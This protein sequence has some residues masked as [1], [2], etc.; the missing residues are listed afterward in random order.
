MKF[1][2]SAFFLFWFLAVPVWS[3]SQCGYLVLH[4]TETSSYDHNTRSQ[5]LAMFQAIGS[6]NNFTVVTDNDGSEF[7]SLANLQQYAVVIFSNT[8]GNS[9]LNATQRANFEAY[10]NAGGSYL[11]IHAASDTY[12]HSTAN[13]GGTGGWDW[14]AENVSGAS[15]QTNPNHTSNG[16]NNDMTHSQPGHPILAG[17]P[18][19]WNKTEEYYYWENGYINTTFTELLRVGSTGSNSYDAPRRMAHYKDLAGGGRAFYTALGHDQSNYTSDQNFINLITNAVVWAAAPNASGGSNL[20]VTAAITDASC[21]GTDG[22]IDITV[23]GGAA[24][25]GF[26][27]SNG[28][29]NEDI[30]GLAPGTYTV[31]ITDITGCTL[32][33]S[34]VVAGS[35]ALTAFIIE[36]DPVVC[37]GDS[38]GALTAFPF[39]GTAPYTYNWSNGGTTGTILNLPAGTYTVTITDGTG[40][41]A[42]ETYTLLDPTQLNVTA[43]VGSAI[44]C[45]GGSTGTAVATGSGGVFPYSFLWSDGQVTDTAFNLGPGN[46]KVTLTDGNGCF[47]E[48]S[49]TMTITSPITASLSIVDP[50]N[51]F[52][53]TT[54]AL[55]AS[56]S[57]GTLP[58]SYLWSN[59]ATTA[60]I[61]GLTAGQYSVTIS[62]A[63]GCSVSDS[64][65]LSQPPQLI[66]NAT[67]VTPASCNGASDGVAAVAITGGVT[68]YS[69]LW[70]NGMT[71]DTVINMAVGAYTVSITDANGCVDSSSVTVGS[72]IPWTASLTQTAQINCFGDANGEVSVSIANG[73]LYAPFTYLWGDGQTTATAVNLGAGTHTVTITDIN[74]C[75]TVESITITQPALLTGLAFV[76]DSISCA[77]ITD[78]A[79]TINPTG[80]TTPYT[81]LWNNGQTGATATALGPGSYNVTVTDSS[82]CTVSDNVVLIEPSVLTANVSPVDPVTCNGGSD[83]SA[84]VSASG[85]TGPYTYL[86]SDGQTADTAINLA[87][88]TYTATVTDAHACIASDSVTLT[89][90]P[91]LS[92]ILSITTD[93]SCN[94]DSN[95]A[96]TATVT[97]GIAP[98]GYAWAGGQSTAT[99]SNLQ[100]GIY[101]IIVTDAVGCTISGSITLTEPLPL[102]AVASMTQPTSCNGAANGEATVVP[103]GGTSPYTYLW[104]DGQ[105]DSVAVGLAVGLYD[106]TVTDA[107]GCIAT[108]STAISDSIPWF[109][110]LNQTVNIACFGDSTAEVS[111]FI[112]GGSG[113]S[114][115]SFLWSNGATTATVT[116][117]PAGTHTVT[118]SDA[119]GC[120]AVE[121]ITITQP[122]LM[123]ATATVTDSINC[124]GAPDGVITASG[125]GGV[126]PYSY[127]WNTG[128]TTATISGVSAGTYVVTVTD[129]N[130]CKDIDSVT[131]SEP[132]VLSVTAV[133]IQQVSCNG[134]NDGSAVAIASGG[135]PSYSYIWGNG[136][137]NDTTTGLL[138]LTYGITVTDSKGCIASS[139][140]TMSEPSAVAATFSITNNISCNGASD[141][142]ATVTPSGGTGPYTYLWSNGQ[143]TATATGLA[144]GT[145]TVSISDAAN[146]T[147]VDSITLSEPSLLTASAVMT[148]PTSCNG[149]ANGEALASATGGTAPYSYLWNNGQTNALA[150]G[151]AVGVY[152]VTVTDAGGCLDSVSVAINDSIPWT[153]T[154]NPT[155]G[156][157]CFGDSTASAT[158]FITGGSGSSPFSYLW[159]DGQTTTTAFNLPAGTHSVTITDNNGC[160]SSELITISQ[161]TQLS[162][163]TTLVDSISCFGFSD[164]SATVVVT[165]GMPSYSYLWGNGQ[166]NATAVGLAAGTYVVTVTDANGCSATD[167]I[168]L[169]QP[170]Q[171]NA[172]AS[173]LQ[174]V[175]CNGGNDGQAMVTASGGRPSYTY[176]WTNG[177]TTATATNLSATTHTVTVTDAGGC[178]ATATATPSEPQALTVSLS[179]SSAISCNGVSDGEVT[180]TPAGG[181][182]GYTYLWSDGQTSATATGLAAGSYSVTITDANGCTATNTINVTEPTLLTASATMTQAASCNGVADGEAL[183]TASGGTA[184]YSYLWSNGQTTATAT[185]LVAGVYNVTVTDA[186]GC[187]QTANVSINNVIPWTATLNQTSTIDCFG[188]ATATVSTIITGG[189]GSNPF[190]YLWSDGQ[191][192]ATASNLPAGTH[193]VTITDRNGCT[194]SEIITITEP[195]ELLA[196]ASVVDSVSCFGFSDGSASVSV[197]G[198]TPAYS[199]LWGNGQ[200]GATAI[201]LVAGTYVV[202]VTDANGC[203]ATDNI[204]LSQPAQLSATA[205][206]LQDVS[207]NGG[208][209][210][211]AVVTASG[212]RPGYTYLWNNGQTTATA[213]NLSATTYTA[214][215]TDAG[216]CT[217]TATATPA[218]PQPLTVSLA[219]SN[220]ISCNGASDGEITATPA[221]GTAG[222]SYLWSNGQT[223]ATA[224]GL[225]AG[226]YSVT[227]T[228]ANGCTATN[229]INITQPAVLVAS[230]TMTQSASCNGA[231]NGEASASASGGT[232]PYSYLWSDGQTTAVATA[233]A[234]GIYTVTITDA[235]G[236][237][238]TASV[239]INSLIP[240]TA[241]IS[242]LTG[243]ACFGDSTATLTV[244]IANG[245]G[246]TPFNYVWSNGATTPS[247]SNL[248]AGTHSVTITDV[249]NCTSSEFFTVSEPA[250]L[251]LSTSVL[252]SIS[253]N[254]ATDGRATVL[255]NGGTPNY[256]YL[257]GNGQTSVIAT[258]LGAGVLTVTVTDANGCSEVASVTMTEPGLLSGTAAETQSI[259]CNG[260]TN[261]EATA[262]PSGGTAPYTYLWSNN[263]SSQTAVGLSAGTYTVT[264]TDAGGCTTTASVSLVDPPVLSVAANMSSQAT[265][266]GVNDGVATA[267]VNGGVGP[268]TYLWSDGQTTASA[269]NLMAGSYS[270]IVTDANA[271]TASAQVNIT[272]GTPWTASTAVVNPI[273]CF[274]GNDGSVSVNIT[275][276]TGPFTY[277]WSNGGTQNTISG[278]IA[279]TYSVT[280][281][282]ALGCTDIQSITLTEPQSMT[283]SIS[284]TAAISC[285]GGADGSVSVTVGGG[286]TPYSYLWGDGQTT[287]IA[288]GLAAGTHTVTAT[289]AG[290][291]T[292]TDAITITEPA[293]L[294]GTLAVINGVS[295]F[296]ASDGEIGITASGGTAPY[297]Y[298]WSNGQ[299]TANI[300]GL[301]SGTYSVTLTDANAC[302]FTDNITINQPTQIVLNITETNPISCAGA[303]DG[304]LTVTATGGTGPYTYQWSNGQST[305]SATNIASG[306][307]TVT[308][309]DANGCS[310]S[311][312]SAINQPQLLTANINLLAPVSCNGQSDASLEVVAG[313]GTTPYSYNWNTGATTNIISNLAAGNYTVTVTDGNGCTQ[314][315][316][317]TVVDPN[318]IAIT[319]NTIASVSCNGGNDG[320]VDAT[321]SG[322]T[323]PYT[324]LWSNGQT[325]ATASN[326]SAGTYSLTVTDAGGCTQTASITLGEPT[327]LI[328]SVTLV[329]PISC[330]GA[331]DGAAN[332]VVSGGTNPYSYLWQNGET[333]PT[334]F[335]LGVG[336]HSVSVTDANGCTTLASISLIEPSPLQLSLNVDQNVS[337]FGGNDG[338]ISAAVQ[339][340]T[341]PYSY[342]W[343]NGQTM[344]IATALSTGTYSLI[345]TDSAGCTISANA[346]VNEPADIQITLAISAPISCAGL[347]DGEVSASVSGGTGPYTYLWSDG[348]TSATAIGL[349][350]GTHTLTITDANG[351]TQ[352]EAITL[353][354]PPSVTASIILDT[355]ISCAGASDGALTAVPT[356]GT[357]GYTYLW[358]DGQTTVSATNLS[359][360]IY[361]VTI[362]DASG[363]QAVSSFSLLEPSLLT[364]SVSESS[365]ISCNGIADGEL[366]AT[367]SGGT[368]TYAYSWSNGQAG[369]TVTGLGPG[370]Y[371]VTVT[372]SRGCQ[373]SIDYTLSEPLGLSLTFNI[374]N[375][376]NCFGDNN[377][378]ISVSGT[379]ATPP[380]NFVWSSGQTGATSSNLSAGFHAVIATDANGCAVS[381]SV[382]LTEPPQIIPTINI[383]N[384]I[385]CAG[386]AD[387]AATVS[388]TGGTGGYTYLWSNGQTSATA[389]GLVDGTY[390]VEITDNSGCTVSDTITIS[391]PQ[392]IDISFQTIQPISCFGAADGEILAQPTGGTQPYTYAWAH[393]PTT[394]SISGLA[395]ATYI[396]TVTDGGNC[397]ATDSVFLSQ[398]DSLSAAFIVDQPVSC[399]GLTDGSVTVTATGGTGPYSF[400]WSNGSAGQTVSNLGGGLHTV[401]ISDANGCTLTDSVSLAEPT[402]I[403]P[404]VEVL[405][406]VSCF[407]GKDGII[408]ASATGGAGGF[409]YSWSSGHAGDT[410]SNLFAGQYI[411]TVTDANGCTAMDS[412]T[413]LEPTELL[414][415]AVELNAASCSSLSDGSAQVTASG[416][417][418]PYSFL[419]SDGQTEDTIFDLASG[420]YAVTVTDSV[421]CAVTDSVYIS[422]DVPWL[423]EVRIVDSVSCYGLSDGSAEVVLDAN[424][425]GFTYAW[426]DGQTTPKAVNLEAAV[427]TVLVTDDIGCDTT[428]TID[429]PGK[430]S[431]EIFSTVF[432]A[433]PQQEDGAIRVDSIAN[434]NPPYTYVWSNGIDGPLN[435]NLGQGSYSLLVIDDDG[436]EGRQSYTVDTTSFAWEFF[437]AEPD[438]EQ[439]RVKLTWTTSREIDNDYFTVERSI[440]SVIFESLLDE[441][442][443]GNSLSPQSYE[444][445]DFEPIPGVSF[446]RLKQTHRNG[447][448]T[449]FSQVRRVYWD[450]R[451]PGFVFVRPVP[452]VQ[453]NEIIIEFQMK[454]NEDAD[455]IMYNDLHQEVRVKLVQRAEGRQIVTF[456]SVGLSAGHYYIMAR[457]RTEIYSKQI[458]IIE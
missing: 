247:V 148:Q 387:G 121:S 239:G 185:G 360:G 135:S 437:D 366:T 12:R 138:A 393:G 145:Y 429:L 451:A 277:N 359:V 231:T 68:P 276:S 228:D 363:C 303:S 127:D 401:I 244:S 140:I 356:G 37:A 113:S 111:I 333:T 398:P 385:S 446:Y 131:L 8:S 287:A 109:A 315:A 420:W 40:C 330:N 20:S 75:A 351:C 296:G 136:Q 146:C 353:T 166:T 298:L 347:A 23:T 188:D 290:G 260:G 26:V 133:A 449:Y 369:P 367:A 419:W 71:T 141:G 159:S 435:T 170:I 378:V 343:S 49:V 31:T 324:Y 424:P 234:A 209:D 215:V 42:T 218:E 198:G 153:A 408:A 294:T 309:T 97:G 45:S 73:A 292:I 70:S 402:A 312:S 380:Y 400:N 230:A 28:S 391:E 346:T 125:T 64:V 197:V 355:P 149:S 413:V 199:Y 354:D 192:S 255:A 108:S 204:T 107:N 282:D 9:I 120:T 55:L 83:G 375:P 129:A 307:Y 381:D 372:D 245:N 242:Q 154:V 147:L 96:V 162:T 433:T 313:G 272:N 428:M 311:A 340:G 267:V 427:F 455:I 225:V 106:V 124:N 214:T 100:A 305:A 19:P 412:A 134:G 368:P 203:T 399:A 336:T 349:G 48:D 186:G 386:L 161:P 16:H 27:W 177:Q 157:D 207:C 189:N 7:N 261:G 33:D 17:I 206:V 264:I 85:G 62:D 376:L 94:G 382:L 208:N 334:V 320:S 114:P 434:G 425:Q 79:A 304:E 414:V 454:N 253:C 184:P 450:P 30:S 65:T 279:G 278:L 160:T 403:V 32:T 240:W 178:T 41:T 314:T 59:G 270:V 57:G 102:T 69:I 87:A 458:M 11:G 321:V 350:A 202:T 38:S 78:G 432:Q 337:C 407:G 243:I 117:L 173:V 357:P 144:A 316:N 271:C 457:N 119:N 268:Y 115:F 201:G 205:S 300:A 18:D 404:S 285:N 295:C 365:P 213:T 169:T 194:A 123:N 105:T 25:Y 409:S 15:V 251:T 302:T 112:T 317:T 183:A 310:Q 190:S 76:S 394:A 345:V 280:V 80:G 74:G 258:G 415:S 221:G 126:S 422:H 137:T 66:A 275:G 187:Q 14:Y 411:L 361:S 370:T 431:L 442:S 54:G 174:D 447:R 436:C 328:A 200:T 301:P 331:I 232:A 252:D 91:P 34:F 453:G 224:T 6:T 257:W 104:S 263:Q 284:Q 98:Y 286:T 81:Y 88:Q 371:T 299:T 1:F 163:T 110:N 21:G 250:A 241:S 344:P 219:I 352:S 143:T 293:V 180:A 101:S 212:G 93:I 158:V 266:S 444:Q 283:I 329:S 22:A 168:T 291:C 248:P 235:N 4:Y 392:S 421:G 60:N 410:I 67:L 306:F 288:T 339:G 51:C 52:G 456:S 179:I 46:Y 3:Y 341:T 396:V 43:S 72:S 171:L 5:S 443:Q 395:T 374:D 176:L 238:Q 56:A 262:T 274:G 322:G 256:S 335:N 389:T 273:S 289:D 417:T 217:A 99:A 439:G 220:S 116:N 2:T 438:Y 132:P 193:S 44:G 418:P 165:G 103:N 236:C 77:G 24:P 172:T 167:N 423:A 53:D 84:F 211:Q 445:S 82:G 254:G 191:T 95:G 86:W 441:P 237:Q 326:L 426:S 397:S 269:S 90:P 364:V 181:T 39:Q 142:S 89:E 377:G 233:L 35:G 319:L 175:S 362:T 63:A 151:L 325:T 358:N 130:G 227:I 58:Y 332:V 384:P 406:P 229:S 223:S 196:N 150:T 139:S 10:I 152:S 36:D 29:N 452:V 156:I 318:P 195:A 338:S 383:T 226:S 323:A 92:M 416:A 430:D 128:Q 122:P 259:S 390:T 222:Y 246:S 164:G 327:A 373:T 61:T 388:A 265:C 216:G 13:G 182:A 210:G 348:Q 281:Q 297:S 47:V 379:G 50:I 342:L 405:K 440:D 249:N 155:A 448:F 118:I 308:V